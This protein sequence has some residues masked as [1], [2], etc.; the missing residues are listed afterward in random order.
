[1][2]EVN[3]SHVGA[4]EGVGTVEDGAKKRIGPVVSDAATETAKLRKIIED[5]LIPVLE[6]LIEQGKTLTEANQRKADEL[7]AYFR[8]DEYWQHMGEELGTRERKG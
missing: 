6:T 8:G 2:K 1:M 4:A 5:R 7:L 3:Q